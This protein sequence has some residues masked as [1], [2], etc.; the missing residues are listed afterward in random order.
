MIHFQDNSLCYFLHDQKSL[1]SSGTARTVQSWWGLN[2]LIS[3]ELKH[4]YRSF[5]NNSDFYLVWYILYKDNICAHH[6][7]FYFE[8][9]CFVRP[10]VEP[11]LALHLLQHFPPYKLKFSMLRASSVT[12]LTNSEFKGTPI[13]SARLTGVPLNSELKLFNNSQFE[14]GWW[15]RI[16]Y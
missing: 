10:D 3:K 16:A 7:M 9:Q 8:R 5:L 2:W 1:S 4:K 13:S 14:I 11:L 6:Q 15:V 12:P